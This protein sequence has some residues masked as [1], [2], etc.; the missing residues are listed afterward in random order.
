LS[1]LDRRSELVPS[2]R[3]VPK[4]GK[5]RKSGPISLDPDALDNNKK[6]I[7]NRLNKLLR[8]D[9]RNRMDDADSS[10]TNRMPF[11]FR[12]TWFSAGAVESCVFLCIFLHL[13]R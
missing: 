2:P 11:A 5:L 9:L 7:Y 4:L 3:P 8:E 6:N 10:D 12:K 13:R 1:D